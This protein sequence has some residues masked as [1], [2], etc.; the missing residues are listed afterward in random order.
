M[1]DVY[2]EVQAR[3]IEIYSAALL[4]NAHLSGMRYFMYHW[5]VT[6]AILGISFNLC[7]VFF[8]TTLSFYNRFFVDTGENID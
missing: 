2:V 6:S 8:T 7:I 3:S 1:T 5:P 4:I